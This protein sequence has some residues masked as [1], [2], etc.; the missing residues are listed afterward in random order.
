MAGL[1]SATLGARFVALGCGNMGYALLRRWLASNAVDAKHVHVV[2]PV[3]GLR[4]RVAQPGIAVHE[5]PET[6]PDHA[7]VVVL[8]LKPQA[9]ATEIPVY[10]RFS[11][12]AVFVSIAAGYPPTN[13]L[14]CWE[15]L[16]LSGAFPIHPPQSAR[17]QRSS[18][19]AITFSD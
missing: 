3:A 2:E 5:R 18:S 16:A 7:D 17:V 19:P 1:A 4:E 8:A 9:L 10:R 13:C 12:R 11:G 14:T 15:G 6:L